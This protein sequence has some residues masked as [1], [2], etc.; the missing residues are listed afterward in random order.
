MKALIASVVLATTAALAGGDPGI[1]K[2]LPCDGITTQVAP[3]V[4]VQCGKCPDAT[5]PTCEA[6]FENGEKK[7]V[8]KSEECLEAMAAWCEDFLGQNKHTEK[9]AEKPKAGADIGG[10]NAAAAWASYERRLD[11]AIK[12]AEWAELREAKPFWFVPFS[13]LYLNHDDVAINCGGRKCP[14]YVDCP[15]RDGAGA[16]LGL[17][18][19]WKSR[20]SVS[21]QAMWQE[22][23]GGMV[24]FAAPLPAKKDKK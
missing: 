8:A 20:W 9:E 23:W 4:K 19:Q 3:G 24:T 12:R 10:A 16:A 15:D 2:K 18:Y 6:S 14:R 13:V 7:I 1:V 21:G 22:G 5:A 17:G 11:D